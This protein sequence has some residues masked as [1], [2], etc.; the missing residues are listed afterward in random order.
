MT[1]LKTGDEI[2]DHAGSSGSGSGGKRGGLGGKT[3]FKNGSS[4]GGG[5]G[6]GALWHR[7][8]GA[9]WPVVYSFSFI[10]FS[11]NNVIFEQQIRLFPAELLLVYSWSQVRLE[12]RI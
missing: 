3:S 1:P 8:W 5:D 11:I 4:G 12:R 2:K 6:G 10:P 9:L 7:G